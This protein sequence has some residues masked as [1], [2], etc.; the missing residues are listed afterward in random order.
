MGNDEVLYS[1]L[2]KRTKNKRIEIPKNDFYSRDEEIPDTIKVIYTNKIDTEQINKI[3]ISKLTKIEKIKDKEKYHRETENIICLLTGDE[4][5]N[6]YL[7]EK[8][9]DICSRYIRLERIKHVTNKFL[10]KGCSVELENIT[11]DIDGHVVCEICNCIN[12]YLVP[13]S[14]FRDIEKSPSGFDED[15]NNFS[16]ILDKFEGK[17]LVNFPSNFFQKLD[18]YFRSID[19]PTGKSIK[20]KPLNHKGKKENT[21]KKI[22]WNALEKIGYSHF[23]EDS[24]YICHMYWGWELPDLSNYRDKMLQDYQDTQNA[25]NII[26][27]EYKRTASLG[28]QFRLYVQLMAVNY[29]NC[30]RDDFKLQENVESLRL[31]NEAWKKMCEMCTIN[32]FHVTN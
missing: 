17:C 21:S 6:V 30:D 24:S 18:D 22:L 10:C 25:W 4:K 8:Y 5:N 32:Y 27:I 29:P 16:R 1:I 28:T 3:I 31:H 20:E 15:L 9:L 12:S 2:R 19:F 7:I 26:K 13:N 23:Y 11:E 14:Y